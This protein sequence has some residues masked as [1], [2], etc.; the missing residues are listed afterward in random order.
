MRKILKTISIA[1]FF[2]GVVA[3]IF[4]VFAL[5]SIF[6]V[7]G[8]GTAPAI[9]HF[10]VQLIEIPVKLL[11]LPING[12]ALYASVFWGGISGAVAFAYLIVKGRQ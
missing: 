9:T 2:G 1:I 4:F 6:M 11:G 8:D 10:A 7:R 3:A 12:A 5:A